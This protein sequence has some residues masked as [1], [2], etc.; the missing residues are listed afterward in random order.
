MGGVAA[1]QRTRAL[2]ARAGALP[3][4]AVSIAR[5]VRA[6]SEVSPH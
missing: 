4:A 1:L 6:G 5:G 2:P 3:A